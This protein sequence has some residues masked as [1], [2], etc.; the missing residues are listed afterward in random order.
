MTNALG[1]MLRR[2]HVNRPNVAK[3]ATIG[4]VAGVI[5]AGAFIGLALAPGAAGGWRYY[6]S[7]PAAA[8]P[9]ALLVATVTM[10][11]PHSGL[12]GLAVMLA[13]S[14]GLLAFSLSAAGTGTPLV[15][16][17]L[18]VA[19]G[20]LWVTLRGGRWVELIVGASVGYVGFIFTYVLSI[21]LHNMI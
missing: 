9:V 5:L 10:R 17:G 18:V 11:S 1:H 19:A 4:A 21:G 20:A 6:I 16:I 8:V 15:A 2:V 3:D 14:V 12:I 7:G 13:G